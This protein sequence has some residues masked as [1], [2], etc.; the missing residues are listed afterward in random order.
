MLEASGKYV[1]PITFHSFNEKILEQLKILNCA[2]FPIKYPDKV[3]RDCLIF[4]D[5]TQG[6][7]CNDVLVGAIAVR[8]ERQPGGKVQL[9]IITL[10]VLAA[11]RNYGVGTRLLERTLRK[12]VEDPNIEE[13]VLHVQTNN[14]EAIRFYGKFGFEV[15]QTIPGYYKKNRLDPP[16]AHIL[17][18]AL[19][20]SS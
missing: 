19:Q 4:S 18:K 14:E 1:L 12:A 9:Y 2:I 11:Y 13:A 5:L 16:D 3:Y 8:L 15:S 7:F 17:T 6:A 20:N 10:G